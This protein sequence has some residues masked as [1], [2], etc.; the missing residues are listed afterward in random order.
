[1]SPYPNTT[2]GRQPSTTAS[3]NCWSRIS[4]L[5]TLNLASTRGRTRRR[6]RYHGREVFYVSFLFYGLF[7]CSVQY[8][9]WLLVS[10]LPSGLHRQRR[11]RLRRRSDRQRMGPQCRAL[12]GRVSTFANNR[13]STKTD[14]FYRADVEDVEILLGVTNSETKEGATKRKVKRIV[15]HPENEKKEIDIALYQVIM[16]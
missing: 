12:R 14:C 13:S 11:S 8:D 6:G 9:N 7:P 16:K 5:R 10:S 4:S 3:N 15:L 1:M 2:K